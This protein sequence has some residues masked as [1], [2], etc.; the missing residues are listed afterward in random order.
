[1]KKKILYMQRHLRFVGLV[2][3][4]VVLMVESTA[5]YAQGGA[6]EQRIARSEF[7]CYDRREDA[8]AGNRA[9]TEKYIEV[10]PELKFEADA[11]STDVVRRVYE[12]VLSIPASWS[13]FNAYLHTENIGADY[14][15]FLNGVQIT[16]PI[17]CFTPSEIAI[18][19]Y[20]IEGTNTLAIVTVEEPYMSLLDEGLEPIER[21]QFENC[22]IFAQRRVAIYDYH[23]RLLPDS[24]QR[25]AQLHLDFIVE[26][27]FTTADDIE[28]GYDIYSPDGRLVEYSVNDC[29]LDA[30]GRDTV[31]LRP[32]IY[33]SNPNR[34]SAENPKLYDLMLY[35]K[36]SGIPREYIPLK[37]G[38]AEYGYNDEGQITLFGVPL[39]LRRTTY[40]AAVDAT[41][42]ERDIRRLKAQGFNTLMPEYPQPLWFYDICDRVGMY[43]IDCAAISS[44]SSADDRSLG[45]TPANAPE[46]LEV[47]LHRVDAMYRRAQNH[48]CIIAFSLG[49]N[50]SGNGYNMYK[51]YEHLKAY[52]DER[53]II[54]E[55]ADGEWN[56]DL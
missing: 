48:V 47:Y 21:P 23:V 20:L 54:Y 28:V 55:G 29:Q 31:R 37:V 46:L 44:P 33:H 14:V 19:D 45:G 25:F 16:E 3:L 36:L 13:D 34:W 4:L 24:L 1:M 10:A 49:N 52:G 56:T 18:S 53:A 27:S 40:N 5:V 9:T 2:A 30:L 15:V 41:T 35:V 6:P 11:R 7:V 17:D 42:T 12:Q 39:E 26:N 8:R 38:F 51:A 22:Y 32:Y 43:V 50:P